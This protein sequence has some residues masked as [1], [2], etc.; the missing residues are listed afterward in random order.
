ML[1]CYVIPHGWTVAVTTPVGA[2][3]AFYRPRLL[4]MQV[5][6]QPKKEVTAFKYS[7]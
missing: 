5:F 3:S 1:L 6:M 2:F 4:F 7:N